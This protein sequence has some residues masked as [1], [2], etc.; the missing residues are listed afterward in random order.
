VVGERADA[1]LEVAEAGWRWVLD[2][3]R[4]DDDGPWIPTSVPG[5]VTTEYRDGMHSGIGGLGLALAEV[6]LCREWTVGEAGL[7]TAIVR[8]LRDTIATTTDCAYFDGLVSTIGVLTALGEPGA[9]AAVARL[10]DLATPDGWPQNFLDENRFRPGA[11]VNDVCLGTAGVLLAAVWARRSGAARADELAERAADVLMA[12]MEPGPN[13]RFV[14]LRFRLDT[15]SEMPNFSHGLA[16]VATTLALAGAEFDRADLTDAAR[17]GAEHLVTLA[18]TSGG[19]FAV[20]HRIPG[21]GSFAWGWCHGATGTSQLF[22]ALEHAGVDAVAGRSPWEWH[23]RCL[24]SVRAS[25]LP[26]RRY[27]GFWDNDG[28]CC[29]TAGVAEAFLDSGDDDDLEFALHLADTLVDRAL[30]DGPHAYWRFIEHTAAD[31]LLPPG[32]GWMQGTTGIAALLFRA[33]R[34]AKTG[35]DA[36]AVSRMDTW[37]LRPAT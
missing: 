6:G 2:Q 17:R 11:R 10:I 35:R 7:A 1:F 3:V 13:W 29:G 30:R 33:A 18:D 34:A 12:E 23:R 9:D 25:G 4:W 37:W 16:G 21:D 15:A 26:E 14:P 22:P 28:R 27:P 19:G 36:P 32:V 31:P 24:H 20:P 8:R 5:D